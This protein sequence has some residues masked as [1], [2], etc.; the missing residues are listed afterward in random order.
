[1]TMAL[2]EPIVVGPVSV[3]TA[4]LRVQGQLVGATVT[5]RALGADPRVVAHG[6]AGYADQRF[7]LSAG[8]ALAVGDILVA[9]QASGANTSAMPSGNLGVGVAPEPASA[10]QLGTVGL[11]THLWECG[12]FVWIDGALRGATAA[13]VGH[14]S[15][16][17]NEDIARF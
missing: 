2:C 15:G 3:L 14:G 9:V 13:M 10:S 5:I 11:E 8:V 1:M 16:T 6:T 4:S 7:A 17:A 12:Q